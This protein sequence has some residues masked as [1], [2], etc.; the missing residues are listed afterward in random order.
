MKRKTGMALKAGLVAGVLAL[1]L[2]VSGATYLMSAEGAGDGQ[3]VLDGSTTVGP[4]AKAFAEY[5]MKKNPGVKITVG[6]TGS[7]N[8]A[9]SLVAGSCDIANTSRPLK[10]KEWKAAVAKDITPIAHVV[11]M[12]GIAIVVHP[13]NPLENITV[14]QIRDLYLGKITNWKDLGGPDAKPVLISR[15]TSSGTYETFHG[16]VMHKEK[17]VGSA[18][19][20]GSNNAARSRVA[21]TPG[22]IGYVGLGYI[23]KSIK[24]LKVNRITVSERTVASGVYPIARPLFMWTNAYPKLGGHVHAFV[25]LHLSPEG[26]N[27]VRKIGF[28]PVTSYAK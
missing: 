25:T 5:Y 28:V 23:D 15:D 24:A 20:V 4:I 11:A 10:L 13:S 27:I 12:D 9:K 7:G 3:L 2:T 22:A 16:L 6:M 21:A 1:A 14:D 26:E 17:M 19:K 8:G 18:E